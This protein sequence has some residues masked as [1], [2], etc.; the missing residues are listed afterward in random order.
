MT[1]KSKERKCDKW[2]HMPMHVITCNMVIMYSFIHLVDCLTTGPKPLPKRALHI[3]RSRA[4]FCEWE[5]PLL[6]VRSSTS[7]LHLLPCIPVTSTPS[8][9]IPSITRC[10]RQ[11]LREMYSNTKLTKQTN[12]DTTRYFLRRWLSNNL[13]QLYEWVNDWCKVHHRMW[14]GKKKVQRDFLNCFSTLFYS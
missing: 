13:H 1:V 3:V 10:R 8:F 4:S 12:K 5:Y 9:I 2:R 14:T 11:F 6:S 7:F